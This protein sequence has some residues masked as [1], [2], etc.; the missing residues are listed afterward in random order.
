MN[1]AIKPFLNCNT[2]KFYRTV[3]VFSDNISFFL[4]IPVRFN[5]FVHEMSNI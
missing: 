4:F 2:Y 3:N 1:L 5:P